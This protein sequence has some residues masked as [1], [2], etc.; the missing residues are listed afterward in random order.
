MVA[1]WTLLGGPML[2][3]SGILVH[4]AVDCDHDECHSGVQHCDPVCDGLLAHRDNDI[5]LP[6]LSRCV[7]FV[8]LSGPP[9]TSVSAVSA[10]SPDPDRAELRLNI[11]RP[12][13]DLPLLI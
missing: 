10:V 5:T 12:S 9:T 13:S 2:C 8:E 1:V 11:P 6:N 4:S 7:V 3:A